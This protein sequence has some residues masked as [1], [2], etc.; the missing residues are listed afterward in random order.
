MKL[1]K[2]RNQIRNKLGEY[3]NGG[4]SNF[5]FRKRIP[6]IEKIYGEQ[7]EDLDN[8]TSEKM[9]AN[10]S[11]FDR[12]DEQKLSEPVK[13]NNRNKSLQ[14]C[15]SYASISSKHSLEQSSTKI[16]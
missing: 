11:K 6:N 8:F 10:L 13:K 16:S 14:F 2:E 1:S 12:G 9:I 3:I 5:G 7:L 15:K 4:I